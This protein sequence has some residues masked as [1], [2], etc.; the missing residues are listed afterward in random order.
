MTISFHKTILS[1]LANLLLLP[2]VRIGYEEVG[3]NFVLIVRSHVAAVP[4]RSGYQ[5]KLGGIAKSSDAR[6]AFAG[7]A[8]TT[9]PDPQ[10][11]CTPQENPGLRTDAEP[12]HHFCDTRPRAHR[13]PPRL[14]KSTHQDGLLALRSILNDTTHLGGLSKA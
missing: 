12:S 2:S 3:S 11:C 1:P 14:F 8:F 13:H 10:R 9:P 6:L 5:I 4:R 7:G